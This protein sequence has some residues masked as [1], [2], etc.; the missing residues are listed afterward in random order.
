[1]IRKRISLGLYFILILAFLSQTALA[2]KITDQIYKKGLVLYA[3]MVLAESFFSHA[4]WVDKTSEEAIPYKKLNTFLADE[5]FYEKFPLIDAERAIDIYYVTAVTQMILRKQGLKTLPVGGTMLGLLRNKGLLPHDDDADFVIRENDLEKVLEL[6]QEFAKYKL[7]F[8]RAPGIGLQI[9]PV[10]GESNLVMTS[11]L[12][13]NTAAEFIK[14]L[15]MDKKDLTQRGFVDLMPVRHYEEGFFRYSGLFAEEVWWHVTFPE[16]LLQ[17]DYEEYD[18]G[19]IKLWGPDRKIMEETILKEYPDSLDYCM[20]TVDHRHTTSPD[21]VLV[22]LS[23]AQKKPFPLSSQDLE[24]L[25]ARF[26]EVGLVLNKGVLESRA[27]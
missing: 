21:Y 20:Q 26:L 23:K 7:A 17:N 10:G 24:V 25:E 9:Y 8:R 5:D 12:L 27:D 19:P 22:R 18:F 4:K 6:R 3:Q 11:R 14:F 16:N 15:N 1:M 13:W 2:G